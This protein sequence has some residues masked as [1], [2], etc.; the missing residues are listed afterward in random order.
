MPESTTEFFHAS[1]NAAAMSEL[2]FHAAVRLERSPAFKVTNRAIDG[3]S[4]IWLVTRKA[5]VLHHGGLFV[6]PA[7]PNR[8]LC[9]SV[10]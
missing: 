1:P 2:R 9:H 10:D 3:R 7:V 5:H 4:D 8:L 6:P